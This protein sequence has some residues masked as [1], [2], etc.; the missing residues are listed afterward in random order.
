MKLKQKDIY[1]LYVTGESKI[2]DLAG[3]TSASEPKCRRLSGLMLDVTYSIL[4][5]LAYTRALQDIIMLIK[6]S[7]RDIPTRANGKEGTMRIYVI[8]PNLPEYP[9]AKFPGCEWIRNGRVRSVEY[10]GGYARA[11]RNATRRA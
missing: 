7:Y 5:H 4:P 1:R 10:W 8:E 11:G 6:T 3:H 9:Q 2:S